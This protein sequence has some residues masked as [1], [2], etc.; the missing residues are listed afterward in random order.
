MTKA[1]DCPFEGV[2]PTGR[3]KSRVVE[4]KP[5]SE[6][7]LDRIISTPCGSLSFGDFAKL[8]SGRD[9]Y[10][11]MKMPQLQDAVSIID[12]RLIIE[13]FPLNETAQ[14]SC[15]RW[16]LRG[17]DCNKAIRKVKTDLE[18][19]ERATAKWKK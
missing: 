4:P 19:S 10:S 14:T 16:M 13:T 2:V 11:G 7:L 9:S 1:D 8:K 15:L 3:P 12:R 6:S 18:V 17:L 5:K